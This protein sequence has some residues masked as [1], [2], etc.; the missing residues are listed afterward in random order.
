MFF[1]EYIRKVTPVTIT[2]IVSNSPADKTGIKVN[3]VIVAVDGEPVP[4]YFNMLRFMSGKRPGDEVKLKVNRA[5]EVFEV[6][7]KLG[8]RDSLK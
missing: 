7:I 1:S 6:L 3:D 5:G 8:S 2:E 4:D